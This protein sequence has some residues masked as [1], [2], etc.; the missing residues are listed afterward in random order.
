MSFGTGSLLAGK[1]FAM[2]ALA[3]L[4]ACSGQPAT[5]AADHLGYGTS[6]VSSYVGDSEAMSL[7]AQLDRCRQ[8]PLVGADTRTE[9]LPAACSQ[10]RRTMSN[11]PGN[12]VAPG[13]TP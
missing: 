1:P 10:L 12:T 13:R 9:G 2:L 8:V 4:A 3:G 11:Q 7:Q 6:G 5:R